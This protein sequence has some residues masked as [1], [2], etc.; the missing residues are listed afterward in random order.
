MKNRNWFHSAS[1]LRPIYTEDVPGVA[2]HNS[3]FVLLCPSVAEP[4]TSAGLPD[5]IKQT[6]DH[7][8]Q[9]LAHPQCKLAFDTLKSGLIQAVCK[10]TAGSHVALRGNISVP[11]Q[12]MDLVEVSKHA[13]SIVVCTRKNFLLGGCGFFVSD[14][15]SG[16]LFGQLHLAL[17]A[18]R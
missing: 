5:A 18:I 7:V 3:L 9:L 14:V 12:V 17:G 15:I 8:L 6:K 1:V 11:D 16:G 2:A 13:A 4:C 10:K